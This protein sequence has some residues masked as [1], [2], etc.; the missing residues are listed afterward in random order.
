M[1]FLPI[2]HTLKTHF[3]QLSLWPLVQQIGHLEARPVRVKTWS[4]P[5]TIPGPFLFELGLKVVFEHLHDV[6]AQHGEELVAV[7]GA[8]GCDIEA[9]CAGVGGNDEV[10]GGGECIPGVAVSF[11]CKD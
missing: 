2:K 4:G 7:E 8:T 1:P 10:G 3:L 5:F 9:L 11:L 6:L